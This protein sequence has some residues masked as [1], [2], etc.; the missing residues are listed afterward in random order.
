MMNAQYKIMSELVVAL[1][2]LWAERDDELTDH[3]KLSR[4]IASRVAY[5]STEPPKQPRR[6]KVRV[7]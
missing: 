1:M 2:K 6:L 3:G 7:G 4:E 5:E